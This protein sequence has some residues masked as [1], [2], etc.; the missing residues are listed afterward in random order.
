MP[1]A[2]I[3]GTQWGDE[4]KGKVVDLLAADADVVVRFHGGNNAGHTLVVDG[5]KTVL[6]LVP[7]GVLH[8][9][10]ICMLGPGVVIDPEVLVGEIETLR[11][12]GYLAEDGWLRISQQAH[13][14]MPYHRA[15]DRARERLR[16]AGSIGTTGRGIGPAYEDKM[17]RSGIRVGDLF[18][19]VGFRD[20]LE[21]TLKEKNAYLQGLL[22]E[23]PLAFDA[24]H[25]RYAGYRE[26]LRPYL[27]DTGAELRAAL[28][29]GRR[30]LLEGAQGMMLDVDHG[31]YPFVTSSS[32][33]SGAAA[34]GA[35]LPPQALGRVVGI[36]KAYTTRVGGGPFPTEL[37]D[38]LG[39]RLR[40]DGDEYGATTGR[41]RRCG[42]F[43][44]VV[45]RQA[46][47]LSGVDRLA[48][49]K[50]DVLT[51][52]DPVRVCT[53]YR[54]GGR[55]L[56]GVPMTERAWERAEPEY[57]DLP[58]WRESLGGARALADLPANARAYVERLQALL[59][60]P[61]LLV[62]I[63]AGRDQTIRVADVF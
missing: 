59:G 19:E 36:A 8:P 5:V 58:G 35:G 16:G 29:A 57:E 40:A 62:S 49:T 39:N 51:G 28:A 54:L 11:S 12:R 18:D 3:V 34:A 24:I 9:G 45:V 48:L 55:R 13:L 21:R 26:R 43:D 17:A 6:N 1:A 41:P 52:V 63:G 60:V 30:I 61:L 53:A 33:T 44:A 20:V 50:L 22:G 23:A 7:S 42:W 4:G 56:D 38:A 2:V 47:A 27:A 37:T 10:R 25:D 15:I 46:V 14:I 31:T 32:C